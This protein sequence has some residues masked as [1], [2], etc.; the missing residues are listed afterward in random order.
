[1]IKKVN[2]GG[3]RKR[4][5]LPPN[6]RLISNYF[7]SATNYEEIVLHKR[8]KRLIVEDE[9][10]VPHEVNLMEEVEIIG[11]LDVIVIH[12]R[13]KRRIVKDEEDVPNEFNLM[14]ENV[15]TVEVK[16]IVTAIAWIL[17]FH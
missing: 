17:D 12:R 11:N 13:C 4:Q 10:D 8:N 14:E 5:K 7:F 2:A 15:A 1:M 6:Q 3:S 16:L 9:E